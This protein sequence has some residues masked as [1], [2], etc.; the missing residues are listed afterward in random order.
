[1]ENAKSAPATQEGMNAM[2]DVHALVRTLEQLSGQ[3]GVPLAPTIASAAASRA[4]AH[5]RIAG[6]PHGNP[7]DQGHALACLAAAAGECGLR[8]TLVRMSLADAVWQA[9]PCSPFVAVTQAGEWVVFAGRGFF[10]ARVTRA[11]G[12]HGWETVSRAAL[13][14]RLGLKDPGATTDLLVVHPERP[15]SPMEDH[16][17]HRGHGHGHAHGHER[18]APSHHEAPP[19][20]LL[21]NLMRSEVGDIGAIV[22]FS[23]ITG[24]LYLA[25]PLTIDAAV[26]NIAFGGQQPLFI[27][28][29]VILSIALLVFLGLM[30]FV[31][32]VQHY[33]AE[34]IQRRL[35]VRI[36]A[37]IAYRLPRVTAESTDRIHGP[38]L[39]NRFFDVTTVQKS[40]SLLLLDGINL[41]LSAVIGMAVLA[42]YHPSLLA[43]DL[44]LLAS[45]TLVV[46]ALGRGAVRTS[47]EESRS[48]YAIAGWLEELALF[49]NAFKGPGGARMALE[50]ADALARQY[51]VRR[52]AHFRIL[53]RQISGLLIIQAIASSALLVVG[54]ALV[55]DGELT[56]G[57]LVAS[58]LIVNA[59]LASVAKLGKH[60]EAWYDALTAADKLGH[61]VGLA[62]E[63]EQG[64]MP[65]T[66]S[67]P[68]HI[69]AHHASF[70][71]EP[72]H[73]LFS[74]VSFSLRSGDRVAVLAPS[75]GGS[76][77]LLDMLFGLRVPTHGHLTIDGIDVRQWSMEALRARVA[78]C[79]RDEIIT[80]SVA[81]NV[82]M[83]R[84]ELGHE[85]V[86]EALAATG[87][88][89]AVLAMPSG[90]ET[91]L[92][93]GGRP[94]SRDNRTRLV[95]ARA[96]AG[97]PR[98]LLL[99]EILDGLEP[100]ILDQLAKVLFSPDASWTNVVVATRDPAVIRLC[101]ISIRLDGAHS[102]GAPNPAR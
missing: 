38:E 88:L 98:L 9:Q 48:K 41:V 47:V 7:P 34:V 40:A 31:R 84:D 90:I 62:T 36:V 67:A 102:F 35:F 13:A 86:R 57:Q 63:R 24:V 99:D 52:R 20:R 11:N 64:D 56:L 22:V 14:V 54:G 101:N 4:L 89:D 92:M 39:V 43:F 15:M 91:P 23:V 66:A 58:E 78:L 26:N 19:H 81:D 55:L 27:Q 10:K 12:Q 85:D 16:A 96:I 68:G 49:P 74:N 45:V 21:L 95:L 5:A 97:K 70:A 60:L 37:D 82:R 65:A 59:V 2:P 76:S 61:L 25:V 77:E 71:Y 42:F 8:G 80:A 72:D 28:A 93:L 51:L 44:I 17:G 53:I 94:L 33:L 30:A 50:H 6:E 69:E 3:L 1:M 79:R 100:S 75:S 32:A 18:G 87:L 46:F 83:G 29:L 73:P